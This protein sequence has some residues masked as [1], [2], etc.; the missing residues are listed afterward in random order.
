M[1]SLKKVLI[2]ITLGTVVV[3]TGCGVQKSEK[4]APKTNTQTP[5]VENQTLSTQDGST[6]MRNVLK[7]MMS[8]LS[9][10][11][12]DKAIKTSD[13]LEEN[14][15]K[16]EDAVKAKKLDLYE[17]VEAPLGIIQGAVKVKP[18]DIKVLTTSIDELDRVLIE[19][20]NIK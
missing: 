10:K 3:L 9:N 16:F 8:E 17:K 11:E 20:Q 12:E 13:L 7:D 4:V 19:I 15:S 1:K 5:V 6:N 18:L 14:W 2:A